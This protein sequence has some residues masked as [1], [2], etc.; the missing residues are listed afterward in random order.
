MSKQQIE[1]EA[2]KYRKIIIRLLTVRASHALCY[3]PEHPVC[4]APIFS[5]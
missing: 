2:R 5:Q 4:I 1:S 3:S